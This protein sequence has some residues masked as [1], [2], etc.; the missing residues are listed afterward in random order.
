MIKMLAA[1]SLGTISDHEEWRFGSLSLQSYRSGLY[2]LLQLSTVSS[3]VPAADHCASVLLGTAPE[4]GSAHGACF[5][6][7]PTAASE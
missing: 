4:A 3:L 1:R 6:S 2:S 7:E 5:D